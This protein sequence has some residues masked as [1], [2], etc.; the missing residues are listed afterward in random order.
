LVAGISTN[1]TT[2]LGE[3]VLQFSPSE[4]D[5]LEDL[6]MVLGNDGL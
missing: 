6:E 3:M 1:W 4:P 5:E 2:V